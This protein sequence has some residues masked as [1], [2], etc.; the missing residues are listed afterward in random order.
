MKPKENQQFLKMTTVIFFLLLLHGITS[1][2]AFD[3]YVSPKGNNNN[4]GTQNLPLYS[5][6]HAL[7]I[8]GETIETGTDN[9]VTIWLADGIYP[10]M[11][12]L[13]FNPLRIANSSFSVVF[14]AE[15]DANPVISGGVEITNWTKNHEGLWEAQWPENLNPA[16][17][18]RELFVDGNR[19]VRARFPNKDYLNVKKAGA[20]RRTN[21]FFE[22][23]DFPIPKIV[24]DVELVLLHDWSISRIALK[25]INSDE[26]QLFAVDSIGAKN[27]GFFNIDNWEANPRYYLDNAPEFLDADYEWIYLAAEKKF[28]LKLPGD[29]N[30]QKVKIH[31]PVS[32]GLLKFNGNEYHPVKN[33]QFEGITFQYSAWEIPEQGYCGIQACHFDPRPLREGWDV[34]PAAVHAMW[35]E[36]IGFSRCTFKNLGGSGLW[37]DTGCKNNKIENSVFED[38]SGNGVMIGEGQDRLYNNQKWWKAAPE[39]VAQGNTIESCKISGCGKQFYGAV[40]VWCGL[41]AETKIRNNEIFDLPYSG[42][43]VGWM[44]SPEPTPCRENT[45]EGNHIHHILNILSDGGGIYMLGLQ[46]GSKILNN[47]IHDVKVNAGRAESNGMFLDEG[48]TDVIV[49]NNLIYNIARSPLRFHRATTNLVKNNKLFCSGG[50]PPIR[51]N[52]TNENDIRKVDNLVFTEGDSNYEDELKRAIMNWK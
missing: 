40:A 29:L 37:L 15:K 23:G 21:F 36:N 33:I 13:V 2:S 16:L 39:Q 1:V 48:T 3:I 30:P 28:L 42:I 50:N 49:V 9:Q 8:A 18:V 6:A 4:P 7:I 20:D 12:P 38:I 34:V 24:K 32:R 52:T 31:V 46:P 45:I 22:I 14:K 25:N 19:A 10:V 47:H 17:G 41:T 27:P 11:E 44:W 5:V 51:Y 35:T 43:S 26:N